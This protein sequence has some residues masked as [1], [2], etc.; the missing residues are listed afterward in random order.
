MS[1]IVI[2]KSRGGGG[3]GVA[4]NCPKILCAA[5]FFYLGLDNSLLSIYRTCLEFIYKSLI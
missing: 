5:L 1:D 2:S 4:G 3:G